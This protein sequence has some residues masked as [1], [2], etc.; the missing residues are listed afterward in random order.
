[1]V[2]LIASKHAVLYARWLQAGGQQGDVHAASAAGDGAVWLC[3]DAA[4]VAALPADVCQRVVWVLAEPALAVKLLDVLPHLQWLQSTWAGVERLLAHPRRDYQLTNIR[5][6]FAP[7]MTEYV[8]C[9]LL[10]HERRLFEL[11]AAQEQAVW[12]GEDCGQ[13]AGKTMCIVGA[14]SIGAQMA[15]RLSGLGLHCIGIANQVRDIAG[16]SQVHTLRELA[17]LVPECD[18]VVNLLPNTAATQN[19]FDKEVF[20]ACKPSALFINV[21]RGQAVVDADLI[22]ALDQQQLAYAVLDVF[23][24]E[25]LPYAHPFWRHPKIRLTF[26]TAAPSF[27]APIFSV[28]MENLK[29]W[30]QGLPLRYSVNFAL[31]Y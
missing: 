1:M 31:G 22:A 18:Y 17:A 29:R 26:H 23:R 25:P 9:H 11:C 30:Q 27:P 12:L 6:V 10:A 24:Q 21:G 8:L 2:G 16:F 20:A 3:E 28:F 14:G 4:Q 19:V 7:L 13:I 5:G 15:Q